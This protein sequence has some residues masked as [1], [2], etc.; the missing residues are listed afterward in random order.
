MIN[1]YK[2]TWL[3]VFKS[4][5]DFILAAHDDAM[6]DQCCGTSDNAFCEASLAQ[7]P[8]GW[9]IPI[10]PFYFEIL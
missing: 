4:N 6:N 3:A 5:P 2:D 9:S 7:T 1:S 8:A 10:E